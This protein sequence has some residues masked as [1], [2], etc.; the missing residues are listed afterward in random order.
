MKSIVTI[1]VVVLALV[2]PTLYAGTAP[3]GT[4]GTVSINFSTDDSGE[5]TGSMWPTR[6]SKNDVERMGCA[7][8]GN[9]DDK[10]TL[11][12]AIDADGVY[13]RCF[14]SNPNMMDA[15]QAISPFSWVR[16]NFENLD[17]DT[18]DADCTEIVVSTRS[19]HLPDFTTK[20]K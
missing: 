11:C 3:T 7:Y 2:S 14:T 13:V 6:S 10:W 4:T 18:R 9:E 12:T 5:A 1:V 15:V 20:G 19:S 17:S 16:F 8:I